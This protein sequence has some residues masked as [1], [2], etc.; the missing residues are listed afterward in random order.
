VVD[1]YVDER[2]VALAGAQGPERFDG[3][4]A[5]MA[6]S[7]ALGAFQRRR[8]WFERRSVR[9]WLSGALARPFV[10]EAV[11][12]LRSV[13]EATAVAAAAAPGATGLAGPVIV[14]LESLP[15]ER[16]AVATAVEQ[17]VLGGIHST[18]V[19]HGLRAGSIRPWWAGALDARLRHEPATRLLCV[20]EPGAATLLASDGPSLAMTVAPCDPAQ[21]GAL[22]RRVCIGQGLDVAQA[23]LVR[24]DLQAW[25]PDE[26]PMRRGAAV[27]AT[28]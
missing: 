26:L 1:L 2:L 10:L 11:K 5:V 3:A 21:L 16:T 19:Q 25:A 12:G 9:L 27:G 7:R 24:L 17:R 14:V 6:L 13:A 20:E 4:D 28:L 8:R 22:M 23:A 15:D 18:L